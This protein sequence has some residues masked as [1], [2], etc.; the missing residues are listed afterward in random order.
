MITDVSNGQFLSIILGRYP[1]VFDGF[2]VNIVR[3]GET[4]GTLAQNLLYLAEELK[5]AYDL[6][7]KVRSVMIY[8]LI[9]CIATVVLV[10]FLVFFAFPKTLPL[11][12]SLNVELPLPTKI[13]ITVSSFLIANGLYVLVGAVL[14]LIALRVF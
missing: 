12:A 2:F 14:S 8:T 11:F 6:K 5:K 3:V 1:N 4:S 7:N 10:S 9:I 13:L